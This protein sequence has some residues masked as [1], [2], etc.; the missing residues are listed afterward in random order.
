MVCYTQYFEENSNVGIGTSQP[1]GALDVAGPIY[2]RY[3]IGCNELSIKETFHYITQL[4][5]TMTIYMG[6]VGLMMVLLIMLCLL[7]VMEVFILTVLI[8]IKIF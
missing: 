2:S 5:I 3:G 7:I 1:R 4:V 8:I 6:L